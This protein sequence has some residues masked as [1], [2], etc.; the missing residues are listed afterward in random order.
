MRVQMN[1]A[2]C[3]CSL[4]CIVSEGTMEDG[5]A[6]ICGEWRLPGRSRSY[7]HEETKHPFSGVER[8]TDIALIKRRNIILESIEYQMGGIRLL[9]RMPECSGIVLITYLRSTHAYRLI[10]A[11][12]DYRPGSAVKYIVP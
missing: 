8:L 6:T 11:T 12:P 4:S 1:S 5:S 9:C 2:V 7:P 3:L 10:R